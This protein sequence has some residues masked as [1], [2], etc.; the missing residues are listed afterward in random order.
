M[1]IRRIVNL[2]ITNFTGQGVS[3]ISQLLVPPFFLH[4]YANG[5]EVYGEWIALSA[6]INYLG[7]LN[8][9]IQTYANNEM[10]I[11]YNRGEV[12]KAKAVQ[13]NAVRLLLLLIGT[14][15]A[16]GIAVLF[17]PIGKWLNLKHVGSHAASVTL[18]LLIL[19]LAVAMLFSLM[20]NSYMMVGKLHRGNHWING[21]RL[22]IVFAMSL[23]VWLHAPF[24]VLA[25][26]QVTTTVLFM[27]AVFADIRIHDPILFPSM[28]HGAWREIG[29]IIKPSGHFG[30][31]ALSG[32][33]TW[34]GPVLLI[35]KILGPAA[36]GVFAL[37]RVVFQMSR[38]ILS[39][40]SYAVSQDITL[41]V[42]QRNWAQLRRLYDMS[43]RV[44][45]FLI[46]LVSITSLLM[47]PFLFTVW[48]HKRALYQPLL[49]I[50]MAITSAV[51]GIKEHKTQFQS[52]SNEHETFA[53]FSLCGYSAMLLVSVFTLKAYGLTGFM[54]TWITW[55]IIQTAFV[56]HLNARLFPED[57]NIS[58]APLR[59]LTVFMTIA[60]GLAIWPAYRGAQWPLP[61]VVAVSFAFAVL[62]S[63]PA[64]FCFGLK[65]VRAIL[66]SRIRRRSV[67]NAQM[68]A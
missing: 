64:Y 23:A 2:A 67:S 38:Q 59:R 52:S 58:M 4:F 68:S 62:L 35:Q 3:V 6:S 25:L 51:L 53:K 42:G 8:Y 21:Q 48:L 16:G 46:P 14:I 19:Q 36:V 1:N 41:L 24:P 31:I 20:T 37:V 5:I 12:D 56:L 55:E 47:C 45:L 32:F 33:L 13:A 7:T 44:V 66:E 18:Y 39:V 11:Q 28:K 22:G 50:L 61:V 43:E 26:T 65:D 49:C 17:L 40:S 57:T 29:A 34:Q 54:V 10:T 9:G 63:I 15:L 30:I 27:L 60:F